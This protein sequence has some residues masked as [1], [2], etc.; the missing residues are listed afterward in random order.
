[1][2][3]E[4]LGFI[5]CD[6]ICIYYKIENQVSTT[7]NLY[8]IYRR[9][10]SSLNVNLF[11]YFASFKSKRFCFF[12]MKISFT[13]GIYLTPNTKRFIQPNSANEQYCYR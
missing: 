1:M 9:S 3:S 4:T 2:K 11:D 13:S 7:F 10:S 6:P 5:A 8:T 12:C